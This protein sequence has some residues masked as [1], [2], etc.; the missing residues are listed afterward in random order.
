MLFQSLMRLYNAGKLDEAA[1]EVAIAKGWID[2]E[3]KEQI[4]EGGE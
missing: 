3:Q 4:V 1:P 2:E